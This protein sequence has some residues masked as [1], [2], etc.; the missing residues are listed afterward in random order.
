[1]KTWIFILLILAAII[2]GVWMEWY[3]DKCQE[4]KDRKNKILDFFGWGNDEIKYTGLEGGPIDVTGKPTK[5]ID[6]SIEAIA[7]KGGLTPA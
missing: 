6:D 1:M 7:T 3:G 2:L 4:C 5:T